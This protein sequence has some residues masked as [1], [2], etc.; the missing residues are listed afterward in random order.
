[1]RPV[2]RT[3]QFTAPSMEGLAL[4]QPLVFEPL[5]KERIWGGRRLETVLGKRIPTEGKFGEAWEIVDRPEAQSVV[6]EGPFAG[7]TLHHLWTNDRER[8]FGQVPDSPRF[9]LLIKWLSAEEKLSLQV[10]PPA[11]IAQRLNAEPKTEF[12]YIA[13]ADAE[14]QL[15]VGLRETIS[16]EDFRR[17]IEQGTVTD[18]VHAIPVT[19]GDAMFLPAGRFHAIGGGNLLVEVQQNSD[20][21]YRVFDWNRTDDTGEPRELHVEAALECIDFGDCRPEL[22]RPNGETLVRDALFEIQ[23]WSLAAPREI[24]PRGQFALVC[25]LDGGL[26]CAG[27]HLRPGEFCLFP[28]ELRN[29]QVG[30]VHNQATLLRITIPPATD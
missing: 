19:G 14:A 11:E 6:R 9:P 24:A 27:L 7:K 2:R 1:M 15:F 28:A 8:I 26:K 17:A 12:W 23:R 3:L 21:T 4:N 30:P 29:R 10:H 25:C 20:S 18:H 13:Q 5:F 22:V 16:K